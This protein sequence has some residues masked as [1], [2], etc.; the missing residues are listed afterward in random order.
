M[1]IICAGFPKTGTKSMAMALR[2]L[3]Y[4]VHDF[5]EHMQ[6]NMDRYLD[7]FDGKCDSTELMEQY[8]DVDVVVDQPA[9]TM[10]LTFHQ[11][12]PDAKVILMMRDSPETWYNSYAKMFDYYQK[13]H[14]VWYENYICWFS[15]TQDR[16][17]RL[18]SHNLARSAAVCNPQ[19]KYYDAL[20]SKENWKNQYILHNAAVQSLVPSH[21]LLIYKVGDGWDPIC[22][23]LDKPVP[24]MPFPKENVGGESGNIVD[25]M[26]KFT[27]F[28]DIRQEFRQNLLLLGAGIAAIVGTGIF[29]YKRKL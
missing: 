10:W 3:G 24:D 23:F 26:V 21:Q 25:K 27:I 12:Y 29:L 5:E 15:S 2:E 20:R 1:K 14:K 4:S 18:N 19:G 8:R 9:C 28:D 11:Q 7:F 6:L 17:D 16:F 13:H 22:T